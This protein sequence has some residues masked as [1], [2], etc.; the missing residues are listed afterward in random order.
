MQSGLGL[1]ATSVHTGDISR[2]GRSFIII[3][4]A[5][6]GRRRRGKGL[7]APGES[8][9]LKTLI[10]RGLGRVSTR[11]TPHK[12][13]WPMFP[14]RLGHA[15]EESSPITLDST[16]FTSVVL[17]ESLSIF[18]FFFFFFL[19]FFSSSSSFFFLFFFPLPDRVPV[20][21][22]HRT[23]ETL[24]FRMPPRFIILE[25]ASVTLSN[26]FNC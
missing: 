20:I 15:F 26:P 12:S 23:R 25:M 11:F 13:T 7:R 3:L 9:S 16:W 17:R 5:S 6:R 22:W 4:S 10:R 18:F 1:S 24:I 19:F 14:T 21:R 8:F 2:L